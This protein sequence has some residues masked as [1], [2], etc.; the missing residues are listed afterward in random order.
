MRK[1]R[2]QDEGGGG[3]WGCV[4]GRAEMV[5]VLIRQRNTVLRVWLKRPHKPELSGVGGPALTFGHTDMDCGFSAW[6]GCTQPYPSASC[7]K[8]L[9]PCCVPDHLNKQPLTIKKGNSD[10]S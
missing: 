2:A 4:G 3:G 7:G 9:P 5:V 10:P 6:L 8:M 1:E